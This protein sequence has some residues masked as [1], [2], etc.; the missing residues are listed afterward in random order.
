MGTVRLA[1]AQPTRMLLNNRQNSLWVT[2]VQLQ[3]VKV[4]MLVRR[5][6]FTD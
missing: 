5:L 2:V 6:S 3:K 4:A 1:A